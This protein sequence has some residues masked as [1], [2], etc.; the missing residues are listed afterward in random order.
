MHV[1]LFV[2]MKYLVARC[3][4]ACFENVAS[5]RSDCGGSLSG[6]AQNLPGC[7]LSQQLVRNLL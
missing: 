6:D 4:C 1:F 2:Q 3:A 7:F 5:A